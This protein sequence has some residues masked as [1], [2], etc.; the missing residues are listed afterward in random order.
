MLSRNA[1]QHSR[2]H[3]EPHLLLTRDNICTMAN[4]P[5]ARPKRKSTKQNYYEDLDSSY[6]EDHP[7]SPRMLD[8]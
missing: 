4:S 8:I 7:L 6:S 5:V 3:P 2:Q 1:A